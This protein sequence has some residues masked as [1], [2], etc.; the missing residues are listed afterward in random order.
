MGCEIPPGVDVGSDLPEIQPLRID[1]VD[2]A[3]LTVL[4]Q[5]LEIPDRCV[6]EKRVTHHQY[7]RSRRRQSDQFVGLVPATSPTAFR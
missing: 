4:D 2:V 6:V 5:S 1:V 3:E 7:T